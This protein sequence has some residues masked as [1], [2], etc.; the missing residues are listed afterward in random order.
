[1]RPAFIAAAV[2]AI[3]LVAP[4]FSIGAVTNVRLTHDDTTG[5]YIS[6]YT[7]NTGAPYDDAVLKE[8]RIARG[9]PPLFDQCRAPRPEHLALQP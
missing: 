7:Q 2:L 8:C 5:N 4:S 9:Q 6:L 3:T 1:M